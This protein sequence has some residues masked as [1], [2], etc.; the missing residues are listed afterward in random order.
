MTDITAAVARLRNL[1]DTLEEND[2]LRL[3]LARASLTDAEIEA[4]EA[5]L[6]HGET[7]AASW[8]YTLRGLLERLGDEQ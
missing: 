3:E 4:I 1:N 5:A 7:V 6:A 2:R 8:R